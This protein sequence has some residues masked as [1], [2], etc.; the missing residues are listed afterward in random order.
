M[1]SSAT[2]LEPRR[3][4]ILGDSTTG[5]R[6]LCYSL[7]NQTPAKYCDL[8]IHGCYVKEEGARYPSWILPAF[9]SRDGRM[10]FFACEDG[11]SKKK[12]VQH[13]DAYVVLYNASLEND[14]GS[15]FSQ[16]YRNCVEEHMFEQHQLTPSGKRKRRPIVLV[17]DTIT[18]R[19]KT[20]LEQGKKFPAALD[21]GMTIT[22]SPSFSI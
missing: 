16:H 10:S 2:V 8:R 17:G 9:V 14:H 21:A 20:T 18:D 15:V 5:C 12:E 22:L 13:A 3:V 7:G 6:E 11:R 1:G 4:V 19:L